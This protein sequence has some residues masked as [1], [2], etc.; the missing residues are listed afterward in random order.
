MQMNGN[1]VSESAADCSGWIPRHNVVRDYVLGNHRPRCHD[2]ST[3]DSYARQDNRPVTEPNV[4]L[5]NRT[6]IQQVLRRRLAANPW[7]KPD[8]N[9][10]GA[11]IMIAPT[12]NGYA[13]GN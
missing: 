11:K 8:R 1:F 5:D 13:I 12:D 7:R 3:T 2:R 6:L 10:D 9:T 4:I